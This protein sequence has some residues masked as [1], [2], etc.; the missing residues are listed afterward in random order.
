MTRVPPFFGEVTF[1]MVNCATVNGISSPL[2]FLTAITKSSPELFERLPRS[3]ILMIMSCMREMSFSPENS[4][5]VR[6]TENSPSHRFEATVRRISFFTDRLLSGCVLDS[7]CNLI[8]LK[9]INGCGKIKGTL[10]GPDVF[11]AARLCGETR[12]GGCGIG[13]ALSLVKPANGFVV[14]VIGVELDADDA[15]VGVLP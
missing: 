9:S 2:I 7:L 1:L 4:L 13:K 15:D 5:S 11:F 14:F 6:E 8:D 3:R 10:G 12:L